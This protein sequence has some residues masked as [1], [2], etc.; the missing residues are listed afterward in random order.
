MRIEAHVTPESVH[1]L[2]AMLQSIASGDFHSRITPSQQLCCLLSQ[3]CKKWHHVAKYHGTVWARISLRTQK[4]G[5]HAFAH[6]R[7]TMQQWANSVTVLQAATSAGPALKTL[8][9][10]G[11]E[12]V[13]FAFPA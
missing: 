11:V 9:I 7:P 2:F 13:Q 5:L 8:D 10:R 3:V 6:L 1:W 12:K 4:V